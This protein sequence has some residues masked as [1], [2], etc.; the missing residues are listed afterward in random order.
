[1]P[2]KTTVILL[3]A[4]VF[5]LALLLLPV[6]SA[7][8][9]DPTPWPAGLPWGKGTPWPAAAPLGVGQHWSY[10]APLPYTAP[11]L[12]TP[13]PTAMPLRPASPA[14]VVPLAPVALP[15]PTI[16]PTPVSAA[17]LVITH[18][19]GSSPADAFAANGTW[20]TL[21]PGA[22]A[23]YVVGTAVSTG[24]RMDA[25]LD[26]S[27]ISGLDMAIYAPNQLDNLNS[28]VGHGTT[29]KF[30]PGRLHWNGGGSNAVAGNW[31]ARISNGNPFSVQYKVTSEQLQIAPK[32]CHS[33]WE[34]FQNG[35][36]V[37]WTACN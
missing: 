22:S 21:A 4:V 33:Y 19:A 37:F 5:A 29:N 32:E 17:P 14:S 11:V 28:P 36:H 15:A 27:D 18:Q 26:A 6:T 1:M 8:A 34:Y 24:V 9:S 2:M 12:P 31:Y 13:V 23:W 7:Y 20:Q 25:W 30:A 3:P 35:D 10:S 16:V